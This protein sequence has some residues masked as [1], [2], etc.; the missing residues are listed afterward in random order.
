MLIDSTDI[1]MLF[2][3]YEGEAHSKVRQDA[4][5][6]LRIRF[7]ELVKKKIDEQEGVLYAYG[8]LGKKKGE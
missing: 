4:C 1:E 2:N 7:R 6:E 8:P 5:A 3:K